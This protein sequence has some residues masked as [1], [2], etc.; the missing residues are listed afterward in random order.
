MDD[1]LEEKAPRVRARISDGF[2]FLGIELEVKR[3]A[4]SAAVISTDGGQVVSALSTRK[5]NG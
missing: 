5:R 4:V 3:N 2:G 1:F